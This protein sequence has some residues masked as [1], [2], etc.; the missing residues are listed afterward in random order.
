M[1][2]RKMETELKEEYKE[3]IEVSSKLLYGGGGEIFKT[4]T[5]LGPG[6]DAWLSKLKVER[7]VEV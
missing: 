6:V 5:P 7:I 4:C 2:G 1:T 3:E